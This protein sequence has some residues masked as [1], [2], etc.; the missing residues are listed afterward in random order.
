MGHIIDLNL[1]SNISNLMIMRNEEEME[2]ERKKEEKGKEKE[3][4]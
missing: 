2:G 3:R 4:I 1:L